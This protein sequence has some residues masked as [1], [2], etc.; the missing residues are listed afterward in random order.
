ME[1][2][3]ILKQFVAGQITPKEFERLLHADPNR[4][5]AYLEK[6]P[7]LSANNYVDGSAFLFILQCDYDTPGGILNAQGAVADYFE[8]NGVSFERDTSTADLY[9]MMLDVQPRYVGAD[10]DWLVKHYSMCAEWT[11][12]AGRREWL[13]KR[14]REDFRFLKNPPDWIQSPEWVVG[15]SGPYIFMGQIEVEGFF[16][17][18]AAIYVFYD[19]TSGHSENIIQVM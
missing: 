3:I 5:E 11:D 19:P 14:I 17:D 10:V 13:K 6:D 1:V 18:A 12:K 8:R 4:F 15:S 2:E 7:N 16:H 9:D